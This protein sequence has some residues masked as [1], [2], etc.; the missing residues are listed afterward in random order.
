MQQKFLPMR[1]LKG[2]ITLTK[3]YAVELLSIN[4]HNDEPWARIKFLKEKWN[5]QL[6][7]PEMLRNRISIPAHALFEGEKLEKLKLYV[8]VKEEFK[9]VEMGNMFAI[10]LEELQAKYRG[11]ITGKKFGI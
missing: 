2:S 3:G 6:A 8:K 5:S 1:M 4:L 7:M 9:T 10:P 11:R